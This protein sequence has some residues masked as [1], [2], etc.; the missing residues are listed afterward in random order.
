MFVHQKG[1]STNVSSGYPGELHVKRLYCIRSRR[2]VA[3]EHKTGGRVME[4]RT[5]AECIASI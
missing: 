2:A 4:R 1:G 5:H 3:R